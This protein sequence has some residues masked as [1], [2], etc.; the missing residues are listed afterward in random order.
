MKKLDEINDDEKTELDKRMKSKCIAK[1]DTHR[2]VN[3]QW[4]RQMALA[5]LYQRKCCK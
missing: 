4:S 2:R 1:I 3:V 5:L